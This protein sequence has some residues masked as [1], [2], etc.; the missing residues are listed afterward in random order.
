MSLAD[1]HHEA[2]GIALNIAKLPELL[3]GRSIRLRCTGLLMKSP[4]QHGSPAGK[5][6]GAETKL[7]PVDILWIPSNVF[8]W[9][10]GHSFVTGQ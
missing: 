8:A 9:R 7:T 3:Y 2:R 4:G 6:A 5:F 1:S 10:F